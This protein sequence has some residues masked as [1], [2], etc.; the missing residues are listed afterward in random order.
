MSCQGFGGNPVR[1]GV[2]IER[3]AGLIAENPDGSG[4]EKGSLRF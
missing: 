2:D 4:R 3:L 1:L